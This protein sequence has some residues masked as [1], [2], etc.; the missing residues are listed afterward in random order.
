MLPVW[1][2]GGAHLVERVA[3][4]TGEAGGVVGERDENVGQ[5][6]E[7]SHG[8]GEQIAHEAADGG[9]AGVKHGQHVR[10]VQLVAHVTDAAILG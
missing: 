7:Q 10:V 1:E 4:E 2:G 6:A 3:G 9:A 5:Q 8:K